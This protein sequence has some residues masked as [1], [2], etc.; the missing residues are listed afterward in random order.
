MG[1]DTA[2]ILLVNFL[3][4]APAAALEYEY[5]EKRNQAST[6]FGISFT[7]T[8][9]S[10]Y[11]GLGRTSPPSWKFCPGVPSLNGSPF[12]TVGIAPSGT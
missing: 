6:K 5:G 2:I 3:L 1:V 12:S 8:S 4:H 11:L 10:I 9:R 7:R